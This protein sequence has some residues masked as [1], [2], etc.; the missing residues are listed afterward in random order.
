MNPKKE[1]DI[2]M[3]QQA[4]SQSRIH[5]YNPR[6]KLA[7]C[8]KAADYITKGANPIELAKTMKSWAAKRLSSR[9]TTEDWT[10]G[11]EGSGPA[12]VEGV[13]VEDVAIE[14]VTVD[15]DVFMAHS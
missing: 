5:Q 10:F 9:A 15:D 11:Y 2:A 7:K 3:L 8:D 14:D 13:V 1:K 4:Y 6:R 12:A